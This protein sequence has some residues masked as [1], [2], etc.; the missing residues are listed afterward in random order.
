MPVTSLLC[1]KMAMH[2]AFSAFN[3]SSQFAD[4]FLPSRPISTIIA[5][6]AARIFCVVL[7]FL[8]LTHDTKIRQLSSNI[9]SRFKWLAGAAH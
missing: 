9:W 3:K 5:T 4:T 6:L 7:F 1:T 2:T 8:S